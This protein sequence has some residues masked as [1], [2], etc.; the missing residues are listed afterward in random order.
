MTF[1]KHKL[2]IVRTKL[3]FGFN[4]SPQ[5][6]L[7]KN[8]MPFAAPGKVTARINK[9]SMTT[10]GKIARKYA[11]FPEVFTPFNNIRT[12]DAHDMNRHIVNFQSGMPTPSVKSG[13]S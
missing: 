8:N 12:M 2:N 7:T 1:S 4:N 5:F 9:T 10:Y 3:T 13:F 11:A 6:G